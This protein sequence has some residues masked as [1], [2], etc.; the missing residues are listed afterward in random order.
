MSKS[1]GGNGRRA[2]IAAIGAV[3][4]LVI[5]AFQIT[6]GYGISANSQK[7]DGL[8]QRMDACT[9]RFL[10]REQYL[11]DLSRL[12]KRMEKLEAKIDAQ[13][14]ELMEE[15]RCLRMDGPR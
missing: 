15:L 6:W 10:D 5:L 3:V 2:A 14:R 13:H 1:N 9:H 8:E 4:G 7:L 12:E 11:L